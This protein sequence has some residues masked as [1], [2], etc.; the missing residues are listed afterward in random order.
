MAQR[1]GGIHLSVGALPP[2]P[3]AAP[4]ELFWRN[5]EG[6]QRRAAT[7]QSQTAISEKTMFQLAMDN[8]NIS[9]LT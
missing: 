9:Q 5:E 2:Q 4:P 1:G 3:A 6:D 8:A 7:S